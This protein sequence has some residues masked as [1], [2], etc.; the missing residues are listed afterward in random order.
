VLF[1]MDDE[2]ILNEGRDDHR[3]KQTGTGG[4]LKKE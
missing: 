3:G 2:G 4:L 1:L